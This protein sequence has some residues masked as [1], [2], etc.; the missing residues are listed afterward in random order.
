MFGKKTVSQS[1]RNW[2]IRYFI[3]ICTRVAGGGPRTGNSGYELA[4]APIPLMPNRHRH[5]RCRL[6]LTGTGRG[7]GTVG[8][9]LLP[10][11]K[12]PVECD[13]RGQ[14]GTTGAGRV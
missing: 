8:S 1:N 3:E 10:A 4:T 9:D 11:S 12:V 6:S 14:T 2:Y 7:T 13:R 5:L